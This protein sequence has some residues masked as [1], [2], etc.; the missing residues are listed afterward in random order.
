MKKIVALVLAIATLAMCAVLS[1][2][3]LAE[4]GNVEVAIITDG[5]NVSDS[6]M[7]QAVII[8]AAK[9][10]IAQ[11]KTHDVYHP[12]SQSHD[13]LVDSIMQAVV[14]GAKVVVCSGQL[15]EAAVYEVEDLFPDVRFLL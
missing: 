2:C 10:A 12:I 3:S 11:D 15:L 6:S 7:N 4:T 8:A 5:G 14:N 13:D 1:S 9:F